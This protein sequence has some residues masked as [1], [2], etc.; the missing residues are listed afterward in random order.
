MW[1]WDRGLGFEWWGGYSA[2]YMGLVYGHSLLVSA[3]L[4]TGLRF[5]GCVR[6]RLGLPDRRP[7]AQSALQRIPRKDRRSR[8][9]SPD[10]RRFVEGQR[11][12]SRR[13]DSASPSEKRALL[14]SAMA[15]AEQAHRR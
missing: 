7:G 9:G 14:A 4:Q 11:R 1:L 3:G 5:Y 15:L 2:S 10:G 12:L 8:P 6:F 13:L